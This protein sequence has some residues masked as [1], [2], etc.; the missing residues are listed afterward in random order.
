MKIDMKSRAKS[1]FVLADKYLETASLLLNV[2]IN[3]GNSNCGIGLSEA[4][5][6]ENMKNNVLNSDLTLFIPTIFNCYQS[7]ELFIKGLLLLNSIEIKE[8]HEVSDLI[9]QIKQL[10]GDKSVIYKEINKFYKFQ[11][12]IIKKFKKT[13]SITTT[14]ELY[15]ALRYPENNKNHKK[16]QYFD[17]MYNGDLGIESFKTILKKIDAIK[18]AILEEYNKKCKK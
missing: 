15:E 16:Y 8:T 2:L 14:Q 4:E 3:N 18:A 6:E 1:Y 7:T 17:L 12:E 5:A 10:Y 13:N 11:V 9:T